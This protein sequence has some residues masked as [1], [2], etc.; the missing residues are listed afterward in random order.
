MQKPNCLAAIIAA[1]IAFACH[2]RP[3]RN[4]IVVLLDSAPDSLDDRLAL[5]TT[6]QLVAQL[7]APGLIT[8][9][10]RGQVVADLAESF[11]QVDSVHLEF[12][13]RPGLRFHDGA[14]LTAVDVKATYDG[15]LQGLVPSPK[16]DKYEPVAR[17]DVVNERTFVF[18]LKRPTARLLSELSLSIVPRKRAEPP[19]SLRQDWAPVGAGPFQFLSRQGEEY[20]ELAS[21][22]DYYGGSPRIR[23]L[24]VRVVP[25]ET[26]RV[27]ELRKGR[28]DLALNSASSISPSVLPALRE[29]PGLRILTKPGTGYAYLAFN[30][31]HGPLADARVRRGI[32]YLLDVP[33]IIEYKFHGLARIASGMLPENH[34]AYA[35]TAGCHYA[36]KEADELLTQAGYPAGKD[37][38]RLSLSYKT[39]TDRF[40]KSVGLV[41]KEQLER[42]G[43]KVEMRSLEFGTLFNDVRKGNFEVVTLKWA[44]VVEPDL[45]RYTFGSSNVPSPENNFGGLNR[46]GY[47]NAELDK[48]L[49]EAAETFSIEER[50]RL[51]ARALEKIDSDLPYVPLWHEDIIAVVSSR[52]QDFE[53]SGQGSL[54]PLAYA[55]EQNH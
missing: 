45:M 37:G 49:E 8:F 44:V 20:I 17:V 42:G 41:L 2:P 27:L 53:P 23:R 54:R 15:I 50:K 9:D 11:R 5:S 51:Y 24:V 31:R 7:I 52:L 26:T 1:S 33:P 30:V 35:R 25:D 13:L 16:A 29:S 14:P 32:C 46:G 48:T 6:G 36:P 47:S 12:T 39:S 19:E 40:R 21:F 10:E 38:Y 43:I 18:V 34:W 55:R 28:A 3:D 22:P 4:G